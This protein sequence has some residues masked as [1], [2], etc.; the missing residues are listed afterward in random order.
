[1]VRSY[2]AQKDHENALEHLHIVQRLLQEQ[3]VPPTSPHAFARS[4]TPAE[5]QRM[6]AALDPH[7]GGATDPAETPTESFHT[8]AEVPPDRGAAS[9]PFPQHQPVPVNAAPTTSVV[10]HRA[11]HVPAHSGNSDALAAIAAAEAA[12]Q[13]LAHVGRDDAALTELGRAALNAWMLGQHNEAVRLIEQ[14]VAWAPQH[15]RAWQ[16][17]AHLFLLIGDV[18]RAAAAQREIMQ[19]ALMEH[20]HAFDGSVQQVLVLVPDDAEAQEFANEQARAPQ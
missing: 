3:P 11:E 17:Q 4:L 15:L 13:R 7:A 16:Q 1:M 10:Q 14:G 18:E 6:I 20:P 9:A 8:P 12:A 5:V 2:V 19:L